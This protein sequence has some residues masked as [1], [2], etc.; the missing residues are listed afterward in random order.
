MLF[1]HTLIVVLSLVGLTVVVYSLN[2]HYYIAIASYLF[3]EW[4]FFKFICA[5]EIG[6]KIETIKYFKVKIFLEQIITY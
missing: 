3:V 2:K 1:L 4:I 6:M 5:V